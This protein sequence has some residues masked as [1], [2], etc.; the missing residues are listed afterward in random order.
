MRRVWVG[1]AKCGTLCRA[2]FSGI[3]WRGVKG[4]SSLTGLSAQ[5]AVAV[6]CAAAGVAPQYQPVLSVKLLPATRHDVEQPPVWK[7]RGRKAHH[8]TAQHITH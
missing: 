6:G 1:T 5:A 8:T 3:D 4:C 7:R 2:D